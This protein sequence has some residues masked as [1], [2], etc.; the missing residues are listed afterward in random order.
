MSEGISQSGPMAAR[1][2]SPAGWYVMGFLA[3]VVGGL[4]AMGGLATYGAANFF[5]T[6]GAGM[7]AVGFWVLLFGRI[8]QRLM[9]IERAI[10]TF[11]AGQ[12]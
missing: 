5:T 6:L 12:Q 10:L 2:G 4:L 3:L 1:I 11:K 7:I 9:D 8:E